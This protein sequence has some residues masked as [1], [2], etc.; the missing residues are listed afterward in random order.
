V[1]RGRPRRQP[2]P[3]AP[4]PA[5]APN[6]VDR[7]KLIR[8]VDLLNRVKH[9]Q[10][11]KPREIAEL[12]ELEAARGRAAGDPARGPLVQGDP[13]LVSTQAQL[14]AVYGVA[15]RT[16]ESWIAEGDC[17]SAGRAPYDLVLF[18]PWVRRK[19]GLDP[20]GSAAAQK[21]QEEARFRAVKRRRA[22]AELA[23]YLGELISVAEVHAA[24]DAVFGQFRL[25]L[26][27]LAARCKHGCGATFADEV[28]AALPKIGELAKRLLPRAAPA[29]AA[30]APEI[31]AEDLEQQP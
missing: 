10:A 24:W 12:S 17:P 16:V 2:G 23:E 28:K 11:L 13:L 29:T 26:D 19:R 1:K 22:E 4:L 25:F 14:A 6:P 27:G 30:L 20:E 5:P 9:G 7:A 8:H 3:P 21:D 18:G 15:L 31:T